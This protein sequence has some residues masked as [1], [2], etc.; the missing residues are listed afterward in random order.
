ML[1]IIVMFLMGLLLGFVGA[2]GAGVVIA[3]LTTVFGIPIHTALGTSLS[4]MVFTTMSGAY[5]H[6]RE[7]NVDIKIGISVGL[8]GAIG[9]FAGAYIASILPANE[10]KLMTTIMIFISAILLWFRLFHS[11]NSLFSNA[12]SK[13]TPIGSSFWMASCGLGIITGLLSGS[14]GIGSTPFIQMGLLSLFNL[15]IY[16][17]A[18]TTMLVILPIASLGGVG[19]LLAGNLDMELLAKVII[20]LMSGAYFGAK[21]T[22]NLHP[23]ILKTAMVCIPVLGGLLLLIK[24]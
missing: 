20:G 2:G 1:I 8:F 5:S 4:A 13:T 17:S 19:Y 16:K 24:T 9:A 14:F 6:F 22:K 10:L 7:D 11:S 12:K 18:G 21:F 15:S 23:S 3:V